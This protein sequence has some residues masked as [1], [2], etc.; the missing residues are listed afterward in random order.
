MKNILETKPLKK[1]IIVWIQYILATDP[2]DNPM[3]TPTKISVCENASDYWG[4]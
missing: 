1:I 3:F 2:N 4:T